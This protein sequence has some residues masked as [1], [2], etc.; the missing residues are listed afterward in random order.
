[1]REHLA[2][3]SP[4]PHASP[5]LAST[6][7]IEGEPA[8]VPATPPPPSDPVMDDYLAAI[9]AFSATGDEIA[10]EAARERLRLANEA[11]RRDYIARIAT[12]GL[13]ALAA[14]MADYL[15]DLYHEVQQHA[16][17]QQRDPYFAVPAILERYKELTGVQL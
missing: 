1:M 3:A 11:G 13:A 15:S 7:S 10:F 4:A 14:D 9:A 2:G 5:H 17:N 8:A 16:P 6:H 12:M